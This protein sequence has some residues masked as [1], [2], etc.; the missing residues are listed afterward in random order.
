MSARLSVGAAYRL[1][2]TDKRALHSGSSCCMAAYE[3]RRPGLIKIGPRKK[4]VVAIVPVLC[5]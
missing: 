5:V 2:I 3:M 4:S 1:R